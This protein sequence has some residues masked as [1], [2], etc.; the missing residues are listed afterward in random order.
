MRKIFKNFLLLLMFLAP[1]V[2]SGC[3]NDA[4]LYFNSQ[5]I[6]KETV[7]YPSRNFA[8]GQKIHYVLIL[9]KGFKNEYTRVQIVKKEDKTNHWGYKIYQSRD[10]HV[11]TTKNY[12][13]DYFVLGEKGYY[14]MQIFSFDNFDIPLA[15]NDFWVKG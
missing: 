8:V 9:P 14:F 1:F 10:F 12:F 13:I 3:S 2:L 7:N 5:P 11:D 15:R 4:L 6:T